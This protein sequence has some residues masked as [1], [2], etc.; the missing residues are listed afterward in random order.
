MVQEGHQKELAGGVE[1]AFNEPLA[2]L[3]LL[4]VMGGVLAAIVLF[5]KLR[6]LTA[7]DCVIVALFVASLFSYTFYIPSIAIWFLFAMAQLSDRRTGTMCCADVLMF[8][9]M[10]YYGRILPGQHPKIPSLAIDEMKS[11]IRRLLNKES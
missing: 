10:E 1:S 3:L 6:R 9:K 8:A 5:F 2:L 7:Y 11:G 4:G